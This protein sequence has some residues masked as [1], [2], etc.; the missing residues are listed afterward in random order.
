MSKLKLELES[1]RPATHSNFWCHICD[2]RQVDSDKPESGN[3]FVTF[4]HMFDRKTRH[5]DGDYHGVM[6]AV[7]NHCQ[8]TSNKV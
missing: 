6:F 5:Y 4:G 3:F 1:Y 8:E 7:C 2:G